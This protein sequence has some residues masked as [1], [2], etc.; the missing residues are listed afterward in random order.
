MCIYLK[1]RGSLWTQYLD[2]QM[3]TNS[4][5][6][7]ALAA[8]DIATPALRHIERATIAVAT[9][10]SYHSRELLLLIHEHLQASG[11]VESA[12]TLLKE[13]Q[14]MPLPSLATP[15]SLAYQAYVQE[16]FPVPIQ[17]PSGLIPPGFMLDKLKTATRYR[18]Y[19]CDLDGSHLKKKI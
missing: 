5:R 7:N 11:M 13:G 19:R 3:V 8:T 15:S 6:A 10:I 14:L 4:G 12:A 9:P 2:I 16:T 1:Q 18:G 17:W